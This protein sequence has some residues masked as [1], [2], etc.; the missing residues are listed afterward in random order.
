VQWQLEVASGNPLPL[1]QD[2]IPRNGHAFEA[3]IYAENPRND[4]LPDVGPLLY[5]STPQP[6][7]S[8]RLEEGFPQGSN[9][10]VYYDPLISKVVAH[11]RDRTEALRILKKALEEYH[12]AGLSTNV[13]FL[14]S[15]AGNE[16]F[17]GQELDTGFIAKHR[18]EL[19][20]PISTPS[21]DVLAQAALF[22]VLRE[23]PLQLSA[24]ASPWQTL[25]FR[26][27]S[28]LYE[29]H[30]KFQSD[31]LLNEENPSAISEVT[32]ISSKPGLFDIEV[33]NPNSEPV[34]F[35]DVKAQMNSSTAVSSTL[36]AQK[37]HTTVVQQYPPPNVPPT[38]AVTDRLHIFHESSKTTL[39]IPPPSYLLQIGAEV[40]NSGAIRA[41]MPSLVVDVRVKEGEDV[42]KG[43]A[44]VVLESMKTE[45][46]L[47]AEV[48]GKVNLVACK[49]GDM[50][51]EGK[52][53]V[54][55]E[56]IS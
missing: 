24:S 45:I 37:V 36:K 55:I 10:E 7:E 52:E 12:V 40:L 53:L 23:Q 43:Q 29:R 2:Q 25:A 19:L 48:D 20:P 5:K 1:R 11:G 3:R 27:F 28:D 14:K 18:A 34:I 31:P 32:I 42:K 51:E 54:T 41:P 22:L 30:F 49:K 46:V 33:K 35:K 50:V 26:R 21:P 8:L 17:I 15:L 47:R 4:F 6:S 38:A 56:A 16:A 44:V 9:I 13:E 39:S